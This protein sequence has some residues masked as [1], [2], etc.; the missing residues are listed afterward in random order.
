MLP[1]DVDTG[2]PCYV[3]IEIKFKVTSDQPFKVQYGGNSHT[4]TETVKQNYKHLPA[5]EEKQF[6]FVL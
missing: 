5:P 4:K 2:H 6:F 3:P 1:R